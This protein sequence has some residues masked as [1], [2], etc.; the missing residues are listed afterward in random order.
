MPIRQIPTQTHTTTLFPNH[1]ATFQTMIPVIT[2]HC[3]PPFF[4]FFFL[5]VFLFSLC[6]YVWTRK[7]PSYL[8]TQPR[9]TAGRPVEAQ[10]WV[11]FALTLKPAIW[12][13]V[14]GA[15]RS[16]Q[17]RWLSKEEVNGTGKQ[18]VPAR[19]LTACLDTKRWIRWL[20]DKSPVTDR[21]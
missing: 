20:T 19:W 4:F 15:V 6:V 12:V 18:E 9:W 2:V 14:P 3:L 11:N 21:I 5:P 1:W 10:L 8:N 7:Q 17:H 13:L 16:T